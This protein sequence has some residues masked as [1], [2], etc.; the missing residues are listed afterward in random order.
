MRLQGLLHL[1]GLEHDDE[2]A[3]DDLLALGDGDLDD[4]RLHRR[5]HGVARGGCRRRRGVRPA[6]RGSGGGAADLHG[7]HGDAVG[8]AHLEA[9]A[10]H[11][12][13]DGVARLGLC[14][15]L[16]FA[17][18]R[19]NVVRELGLDPAREH[20][21][22]SVFCCEGRVAHDLAVEGQHGRHARDLELVERA[23]RAL[24]R[25]G[26]VTPR[27]DE[28]AEQRV[29][30]SRDAVTGGDAGVEADAGATERLE[31]VDAAGLGQKAAPRVFA[32]DAEL[33]RV[34]ERFGVV[35]VE[36][37]ALGEAELLA[38][39]VDAGH[40][41]GDGVLDL[42]ARVDLEE[43]DGAV[44]SD[45]ELARAGADVADLAEDGLR[46]FVEGAVLLVGEERGGRLFDELLVATL[47]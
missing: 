7:R 23:A 28:L 16:G 27:D 31:L 47:Q 37:A 25:L 34:A 35:V 24:E 30:R 3:L 20:A 15:R 5:L 40:L 39:E 11:L 9:L 44:G 45:E 33:D 21:E 10:R 13:D 6:R 1:H 18:P 41:F 14:G 19:R 29:E 17:V 32:V 43:R 38:H 42:Q 2:V 36:R 12:D 4:G 22:L 26:A 46:R 8:Q